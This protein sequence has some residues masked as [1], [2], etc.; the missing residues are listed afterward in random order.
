MIGDDNDP[1][2]DP[3]DALYKDYSHGGGDKAYHF[4][5]TFH[6]NWDDWLEK[7]WRKLFG[8]NRDDI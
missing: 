3:G 7:G 2:E 6:V 5:K 8:K 4:S 1:L